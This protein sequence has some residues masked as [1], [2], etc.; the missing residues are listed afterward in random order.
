VRE[1]GLLG[2]KACAGPFVPRSKWHPEIPRRDSRPCSIPVCLNWFPGAI[3][4]RS[5][6]ANCTTNGLPW[7]F[8]LGCDRLPIVVDPGWCTEL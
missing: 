1:F 2:L 6:E 5:Q 7:F 8:A 3:A 4:S